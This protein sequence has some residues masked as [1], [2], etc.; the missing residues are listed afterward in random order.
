MNT[1]QL[2]E[3]ILFVSPKPL[4]AKRIAELIGASAAEAED[5][6]Q[7]L[8]E[9]MRKGRGGLRLLQHNHEYQLVTSPESATAV[10]LFLKE[11]QT[12]ELTR[13]ALET[14]TI[15][16]YRGPIAKSELDTI[17]GVNCTLILRSLMIRGLVAAERVPGSPQPHYRM[18]ADFLR[19]LGLTNVAELPEYAA[20]NADQ[21]LQDLLRVEKE[22]M[23]NGDTTEGATA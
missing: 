20:L 9:E 6:L 15:V 5:T 17:R 11:E 8:A 10:E 2:V 13:A 22:R 4:T 7:A 23:T 3:S 21:H 12:G 19:H 18:T 16:A 14:L 1:R